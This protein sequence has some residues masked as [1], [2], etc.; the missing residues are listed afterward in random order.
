MENLNRYGYEISQQEAELILEFMY[1]F[2]KL[3]LNQQL[4]KR[5][6]RSGPLIRH[7][8]SG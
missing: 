7:P 6:R 1:D 2:A 5:S 3:A 4:Q 8:G